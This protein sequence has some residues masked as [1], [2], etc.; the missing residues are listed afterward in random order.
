MHNSQPGVGTFSTRG[1]TL[2]P[3][4]KSQKAAPK[5]CTI[6]DM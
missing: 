1:G 6:C 4:Q 5:H 2:G 3:E